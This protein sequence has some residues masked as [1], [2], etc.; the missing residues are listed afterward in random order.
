[1]LPSQIRGPELSNE[2]EE[3]KLGI[4]LAPLAF[5]GSQIFISG[6][7]VWQWNSKLLTLLLIC[8]LYWTSRC[9]WNFTWWNVRG[10]IF[11]SHMKKLLARTLGWKILS[12]LKGQPTNSP[13]N[14]LSKLRRLMK[15]R[16]KTQTASTGLRF[17]YWWLP[18]ISEMPS[19]EARPSLA[20]RFKAK[21]E[22][23]DQ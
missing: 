5:F 10:K 16:E 4:A 3:R 9:Q 2:M 1:M 23:R 20:R 14:T 12:T 7:S 8:I 17:F 13:N 18:W 19:L 21:P 22:L 15:K 6:W 11:K